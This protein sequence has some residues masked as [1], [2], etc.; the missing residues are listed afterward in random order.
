VRTQR[1]VIRTYDNTG[2]A[3]EAMTRSRRVA[4]V[5]LQG[6]GLQAVW[7]DCTEDCGDALG[8]LK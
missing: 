8:P 1:L 5:I 7:R 2:L 3:R 4:G 6:A